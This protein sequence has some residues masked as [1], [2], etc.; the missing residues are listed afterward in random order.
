[1]YGRKKD[2]KH[3]SDNPLKNNKKCTEVPYIIR[4]ANGSFNVKFRIKIYCENEFDDYLGGYNLRKGN[5][6][7]FL[8]FML[9]DGSQIESNRLPLFIKKG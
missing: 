9:D 4:K 7:M 1:M 2:K 6:E 3:Y 8:R 5:Y